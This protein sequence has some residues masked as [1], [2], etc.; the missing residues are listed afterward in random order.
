[1]PPT[2]P[3]SASDATPT[4]GEC[5]CETCRPNTKLESRMILCPV[6]GNKR[7]PRATHHD[8]A[9]TGSNEPGQRGSSW[10][11][12]PT[13]GAV[14]AMPDSVIEGLVNAEK[15]VRSG[16]TVTMGELKHRVE[17]A[18]GAGDVDVDDLERK[19]RAAGGPW[20]DVT[21]DEF[22]HVATP[23]AVL[24]LI[25]E[26]DALRAAVEKIPDIIRK[27]G[28][29]GPGGVDITRGIPSVVYV[30]IGRERYEDGFDLARETA[31][32]TRDAAA[33]AVE[34]FIRAA[35]AR[36]SA[37]GETTDGGGKD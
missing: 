27:S 36:G 35:L 3:P 26:R 5:W 32:Y 8:N 9:C 1:M 24:A 11:N 29:P 12:Y 23:A 31:E 13:P 25:A 10:E 19:A 14:G 17:S 33:G 22:A 28:E 18:G 34:V 7:C 6:C 16:E 30:G 21:R 2:N 37:A 15:Y 4:P 20:W